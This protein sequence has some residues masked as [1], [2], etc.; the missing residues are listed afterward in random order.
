MGGVRR[1]H[2]LHTANSGCS[3]TFAHFYQISLTALRNYKLMFM[4]TARAHAHLPARLLLLWNAC[5]AKRNV[6]LLPT[7]FRFEQQTELFAVLSFYSVGPKGEFGDLKSAAMCV[8]HQQ[9]V[10]GVFSAIY[11]WLAVGASRCAQQAAIATTTRTARAATA[12]T[13]E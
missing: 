1:T 3:T 7:A 12:K 6:W 2:F 11:F 9:S 5:Q 8:M 4:H 13:D 10:Y